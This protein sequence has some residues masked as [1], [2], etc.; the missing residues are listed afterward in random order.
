LLVYIKVSIKVASP[1]VKIR[2][3]ISYVG[4]VDNPRP[5]KTVVIGYVVSSKNGGAAPVV[6]DKRLSR[7]D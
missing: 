5:T 6:G 7:V 2:G 4:A 1:S 3:S